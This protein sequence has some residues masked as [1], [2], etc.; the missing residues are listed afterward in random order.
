MAGRPREFD[1]DAAL[2]KAQRAFWTRGYE[3]TSMADLV[4][5]LGIASARIY[6]A[7]GSKEALFREA[8][9]LYEIEDGG[10][11]TRALEEERT[12]RQAIER[13]LREAIDLY[14]RPG[15]PKGCMVV[16]AATNCTA[17]NEAVA[18]WLAERRRMRTASITARM[19]RAAANGELPPDADVG[20]LGD[21]YA[22]LLHGLSVQ[23]RD[24]VPRDRLLALIPRAM[25]L[26][27]QR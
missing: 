2:G 13:I 14:T 11:A 25:S 22:A 27:D 20:A 15:G 5:A 19:E 10:F 23:A 4:A 17:E 1:R 26:I 18:E 24:G 12:A 7:F 3:G 16:S 9:A 21:H 6:A 8:V